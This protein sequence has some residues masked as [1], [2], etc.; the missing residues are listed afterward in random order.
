[1]E[2]ELEAGLFDRP[3]AT[4]SKSESR[5]PRILGLESEEEAGLRG[6]EQCVLICDWTVRSNVKTR[7]KSEFELLPGFCSVFLFSDWTAKSDFDRTR[8]DS[9]LDSMPEMDKGVGLRGFLFSD[10]RLDLE[11]GVRKSKPGIGSSYERLSDDF[12]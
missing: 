4:E 5:E 2:S 7:N 1:M 8:N 3:L 12:A 11:G 9:G 10:W 6:K